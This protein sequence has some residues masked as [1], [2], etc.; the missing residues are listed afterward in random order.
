[1]SKNNVKGKRR[2][3]DKA[4]QAHGSSDEQEQCQKKEK[5]CQIT[6]PNSSLVLVGQ[7]Q[8]QKKWMG[9]GTASTISKVDLGV[10]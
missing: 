3:I 2:V 7:G 4:Y 5:G 1:M 10:S 8:N 9:C 6:D